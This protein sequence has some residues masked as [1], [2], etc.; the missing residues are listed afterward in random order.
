[1]PSERRAA[2]SSSQRRRSHHATLA[3]EGGIPHATKT[4]QTIRSLYDTHLEQARALHAEMLGGAGEH[5]AR[6]NA[7]YTEADIR[8]T[9]A[10]VDDL[11]LVFR[12]LRRGRFKTD[13]A[14]K[15]LYDDLRWRLDMDIEG[16]AGRAL[17]SSYMSATHDGIP[18]FWIHSR[19]RDRLGRP[20]LYMC[21]R[22]V[23]RTPDGSL[24][25]LKECVLAVLEVVRRYLRHVNRRRR[26]SAPPVIQFTVAVDM[27]GAGMSNFELELLPFALDLLKHHFP[28]HFDT[29]YL[30]NY[31]WLH[32]GMWG[33]TKPL[34]PPRL[35]SRIFFPTPQELMEQFDGMLPRELGG[36]L[37]VPLAPDTSD[38]FNHLGRA[39]A[40]RDRTEHAL[41]GLDAAGRMRYDYESIYDVVSR[42]STPLPG[43]EPH[44]VPDSPRMRA[45]SRGVPAPGL[46]NS[47]RQLEEGGTRQRS[48]SYSAAMEPLPLDMQPAEPRV[49]GRRRSWLSWWL[50][51]WTSGGSRST[52]AAPPEEGAA[53]DA[54]DAAA[55][56]LSMPPF[57]ED[58]REDVE[59]R[60]VSQ[61]FSRRAHATDS[62]HVSPYNRENPYFGYPAQY[63]EASSPDSQPGSPTGGTARRQLR[64]QRRKRDL[65]RTLTYL[66]VLRLL[67]RYQQLRRCIY[68]LVWVIRGPRSKERRPS[69]WWHPR[70][71]LYALD[72]LTR[73]LWRT[74]PHHWLLVLLLLWLTRTMRRVWRDP[75][76]RLLTLPALLQRQQKVR[77]AAAGAA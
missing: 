3:R 61:F 34:L 5:L 23:E 42:T 36:L 7:G 38:V 44:S 45:T 6:A 11:E 24:E 12:F 16:I 40:W 47:L 65:L 29:V 10:Y 22:H 32:A 71:W 15:L 63:V 51:R 8:R 9:C 2:G 31:S 27:S 26:P 73:P 20:C 13:A 30:I 52:P 14:R 4:W 68:A 58:T 37:H 64:V 60:S 69:P 62:A 39:A 1:M 33:M 70:A 48:A 56:Q 72:A 21:L 49:R 76:A 19:F 35:L 17:H 53:Q 67:D 75:S 55:P 59:Q 77:V 46:V 54:G 18:L 25:E 41:G 43:S 57:S 66:F 28:G 50:P 74:A